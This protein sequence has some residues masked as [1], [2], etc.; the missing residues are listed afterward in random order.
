MFEEIG[1]KEVKQAKNTQHLIEYSKT[2]K[3]KETQIITFHTL[4][5]TVSK[6]LGVNGVYEGHC[7]FVNELQAINKQVEELGWLEELDK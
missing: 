7:I 2:N 3:Y 4:A 1:Y 6:D 5:K